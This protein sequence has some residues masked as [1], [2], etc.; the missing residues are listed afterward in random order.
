MTQIFFPPS[1][2]VKQQKTYCYINNHATVVVVKLINIDDRHCERVIFP[3]E[4]FLFT[5][6]DSCEIE[7]HQQTNT[8]IIK[9][10]IACS[11]LEVIDN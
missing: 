4:K 2:E 1:P 3:A 8:G 5:A 6:D 11:K 10:I 9:D 7:V